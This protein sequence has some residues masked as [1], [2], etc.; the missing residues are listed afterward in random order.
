MILNATYNNVFALLWRLVLLVEE[1]RISRENQ[2]YHKSLT[3]LDIEFF[4]NL[5]YFTGAV[6]IVIV[7]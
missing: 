2:T 4:Q 5:N 7:W 6:V 3:K 1:T